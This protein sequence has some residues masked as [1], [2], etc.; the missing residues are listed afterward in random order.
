M[1]HARHARYGPSV[2]RSAGPDDERFAATVAPCRPTPDECIWATSESRRSSS[3]GPTLTIAFATPRRRTRCRARFSFATAALVRARYCICAEEPWEGSRYRIHEEQS[4][5]A[6]AAAVALRKRA[7]RRLRRPAGANPIVRSAP[8]G[9]DRRDSDV[10]KAIARCEPARGTKA[11]ARRRLGDRC[12]IRGSSS[13]SAVADRGPAADGFR[14]FG[15]GGSRVVAHSRVSRDS[16]RGLGRVVEE[17][18]E[19]G[20]ECV[21]RQVSSKRR[22]RP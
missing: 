18:P 13:G 17:K 16:T 14:L 12:R 2:T 8:G 21:G 1:R 7:R 19:A 22:V 11:I 5:A 15:A 4:P 9:D 3:V 10:A 6:V 20:P